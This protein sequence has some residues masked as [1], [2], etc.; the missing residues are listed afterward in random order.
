MLQEIKRH[1][2]RLPASANEYVQTEES[3]ASFIV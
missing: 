1:P 3:H 2:W